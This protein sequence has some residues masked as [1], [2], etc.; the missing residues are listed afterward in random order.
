[1]YEA[2][3]AEAR[4]ESAEGGTRVADVRS[5]E[6]RAEVQALRQQSTAAAYPLVLELPAL[7]RSSGDE[8]PDEGQREPAVDGSEVVRAVEA[9]DDARDVDAEDRDEEGHDQLPPTHQPA[10]GI[11]Q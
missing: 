11:L 2:A 8:H 9:D 10:L 7:Q 1:M 6:A 5:A 3:E 4:G